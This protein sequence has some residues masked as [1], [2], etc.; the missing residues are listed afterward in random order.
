MYIVRDKIT[1]AIIHTNHAPPSQNLTDKEVYFYFAPETMEIGKIDSHELPEHYRITADCEI[2][3]L[4]LSEKAEKNLIALQLTQKIVGEGAN[5]KIVEM[6]LA[7][8]VAEGLILLKPNQKLINDNIAE[9]TPREM[10]ADGSITLEEI[11]QGQIQ[12]YSNQSLDKKA[13]LLPDYKLQNAILG[14]YDEQT[15]ANYRATIQAFRGEFYRLQALVE[16]AKTLDELEAITENFPTE[17]V[18][19]SQPGRAA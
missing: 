13:A 6:S 5:E 17:I 7:E 10:L 8:Q 4:T 14:I 18:A 11:K 15:L 9:K 12:N 3:E 19:A 2:V 1:K 16:Q